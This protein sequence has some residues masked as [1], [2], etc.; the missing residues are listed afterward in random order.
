MVG[1]Y[2]DVEGCLGT[3]LVGLLGGGMDFKIVGG[4]VMTMETGFTLVLV[5]EN[6]LGGKGRQGS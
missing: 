1:T 3:A 5:G 6:G 2:L 4:L